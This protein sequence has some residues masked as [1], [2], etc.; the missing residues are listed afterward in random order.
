MSEKVK[1]IRLFVAIPVPEAVACQIASFT[2]SLKHLHGYR[3]V[4]S[5][6]WHITLFFL[7]NIPEVRFDE[8]A[9]ILN[10]T[11]S[12]KRLPE[13]QFDAFCSKINTP[14]NG[15]IWARFHRHELFTELALQIAVSVRDVIAFSPIHPDPIPHIT[16][17]RFR[18]I[19]AEAL[20]DFHEVTG[21]PGLKPGFCELWQSVTGQEGV[22]YKPL[23]RYIFR[24]DYS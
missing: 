24:P 16:L 6:N 1:T 2:E 21:I 20:P 10:M 15:M 18:K 5:K 9:E 13:L 22:V 11:L 12:G 17:A 4:P 19:E 3:W 8:T 7:G 23:E 14:K